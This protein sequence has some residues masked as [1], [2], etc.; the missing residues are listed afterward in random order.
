MKR[1]FSHFR[2]RS[3]EIFKEGY[4]L[5]KLGSDVSAGLTVGMIALP[6]SLALGIA[7]VPLGID[8]ALPVPALG[9]VTAIVAGFIISLLGGSRVQVGGPTAAFVPIILLIVM[10]HGYIGLLLATMMAGV[11]LIVMG[12]SGLGSLV[13]Y[14]PWPVTTGFTTGIAVAI[15]ITQVPDF[16]GM[17]V[18]SGSM[19]SEFVHKFAWLSDHLGLSNWYSLLLAVVCLA[20][21]LAWPRMGFKRVP[22]S[23]VAVVVAAVFVQLSGWSDWASVETVGTKFGAGAIPDG[24]PAPAWPEIDW[25]MIRD[26]IGPATAIAILGAIES[27]LSAVVAD[28]ISGD[29][30][31]SNTELVAQGVA[32][33]VCPL[34]GG[35]PATGAIARTSANISSGG[36]TPVAGMVHSLALLVVIL[37]GSSLAGYIPMPAMAAVLVAV[38]MRMGEWHEL[39]RLLKMPR[40]DSVV[41]VTTMALTI[42]FDLVIAIEVGMVL[43]AMLFIRRISSSTE[44]SLVTTNDVLERP[45]QIAQGKDIPDGVVVFRIFG[46]FLFGTAEKLEDALSSVGP[47]P[48]VF[49]LRLHLVTTMDA[50]GINA[51]ES[52]VERMANHGGT[53]VLSG[54]HQQPLLTL[55]KFGLLDKIGRENICMTFDEALDRARNLVGGPSR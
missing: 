42:V 51:L 9:I 15:M 6:L 36:R 52:V 28:G 3:L 26:L 25:S 37:L 30:H 40:G 5:A 2:P 39:R 8:T 48:R 18:G 10:E 19:P 21:I 45:E 22:G 27:L 7:S 4:S 43:A 20:L 34:F 47:W 11:I 32:N 16:F 14:I 49:I 35:L 38:A 23:V 17:E 31:D 12:L 33:L 1:A 29:R 13:R 50:T 53:I 44:V 46:P 41:L 24:L 54:I 55:R